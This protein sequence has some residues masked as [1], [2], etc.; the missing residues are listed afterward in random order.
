MFEA[1]ETWSP[2]LSCFALSQARNKARRGEPSLARHEPWV[3]AGCGNAS[4]QI[5][6]AHPYAVSAQQ[7]TRRDV[8]GAVEGSVNQRAPEVALTAP[9]LSPLS[10]GLL[11]T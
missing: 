6:P 4:R 11:T 3:L 9:G 8:F 5:K 7:L 1:P 2:H 10:L